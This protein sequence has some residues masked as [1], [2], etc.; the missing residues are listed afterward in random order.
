MIRYFSREK[1]LDFPQNFG[2]GIG[3]LLEGHG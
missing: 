1:I 3:K 2:S